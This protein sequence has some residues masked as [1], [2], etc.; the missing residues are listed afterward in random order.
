MTFFGNGGKSLAPAMSAAPRSTARSRAAWCRRLCSA[1]V[2]WLSLLSLHEKE[3]E[4]GY[5]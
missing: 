3:I 1:D 2:V 4:S 5:P